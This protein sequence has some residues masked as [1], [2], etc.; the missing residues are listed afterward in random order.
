MRAVLLSL[1]VC[2]TTAAVVKEEVIVD[3]N[4]LCEF[5]GYSKIATGSQIAKIN[6]SAPVY[7]ITFDYNI[8]EW[9]GD[10]GG[11]TGDNWRGSVL[12]LYFV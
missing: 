9:I 5:K 6:L 8:D 11:S 12:Q 1:A 7:K 3:C 2:L 10:T 4:E